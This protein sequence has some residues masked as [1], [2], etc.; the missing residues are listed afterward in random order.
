[1]IISLVI[2]FNYKF[3]IEKLRNQRKLWSA[4]KELGEG[5][6]LDRI[7]FIFV[8]EKP[9]EILINNPLYVR[10][11]PFN[12]ELREIGSMSEVRFHL[13]TH[14]N[15]F[16]SLTLNRTSHRLHY[17]RASQFGVIPAYCKSSLVNVSAC[18]SRVRIDFL[19]WRKVM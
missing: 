9:L 13:T 18:S 7:Q 5:H 15:P 17:D 10:S 14:Y 16:D 11:L 6:D 3:P 2:K 12:K 4:L 1:M 19:I 8:Q